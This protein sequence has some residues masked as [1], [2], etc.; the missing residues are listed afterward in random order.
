MNTPYLTCKRA[1]VHIHIQNKTSRFCGLGFCSISTLHGNHYIAAHLDEV[2]IYFCHWSVIKFEHSR[3]WNIASSQN[4]GRMSF[5]PSEVVNKRTFHNFMSTGATEKTLHSR[6]TRSVHIQTIKMFW[7]ASIVPNVVHVAMDKWTHLVGG[8]FSSQPSISK[9][10]N[11][12]N[13]NVKI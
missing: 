6:T 3:T 11:S 8:W 5:L 9:C 10:I 1:Q 4:V 13:R 12:L 2:I 7:H